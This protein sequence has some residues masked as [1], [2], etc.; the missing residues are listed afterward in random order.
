M[1][2]LMGL[3][4][5]PWVKQS[6]LL[7][8]GYRQ[9]ISRTGE[10]QP[11]LRTFILVASDYLEMCFGPD[12]DWSL[13]DVNEAL[14]MFGGLLASADCVRDFL[15]TMIGFFTYLRSIGRVEAGCAADVIEQVATKLE[16][17]PSDAR[18]AAVAELVEV[19]RQAERAASAPQDM[20]QLN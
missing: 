19:L 11:E 8:E 1:Y 2:E 14:E 13:F 5:P 15:W 20:A 12:A 4:L 3:P 7:L 17:A 9:E 16:L 18:F 10:P 6:Y